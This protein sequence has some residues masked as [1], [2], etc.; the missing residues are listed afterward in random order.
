[1]ATKKK[2]KRAKSQE[3]P[4]S[5]D[6]RRFLNQALAASAGIAV[7]GWLPHVKATPLLSMACSP[8]PLAANEL[9]NP[10]EITSVGTT[11]RSVLVVKNENRTVPSIPGKSFVL[12]AYE[13]YSG[14]KID[15]TKRVT[16]PG[17]Y[18]PGPTF[19]AKVGDTI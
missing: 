19:R 7:S 1:M 18:G 15:P 9:L 10:G 16:K 5:Y 2:T 17:V 12:R 13:G 6:R 8:S 4:T 3:S 11:L 14:N